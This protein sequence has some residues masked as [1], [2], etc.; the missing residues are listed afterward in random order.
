G[1]TRAGLAEDVRELLGESV[2][3]VR[4]AVRADAP[5][6]E[7]ARLAGQTPHELFAAYLESAGVDDPRLSALFAQLLDEVT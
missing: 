4:L 6:G 1:P 3:E 7:R 2:V 5:R